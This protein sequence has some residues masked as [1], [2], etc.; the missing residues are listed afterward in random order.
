MY[1]YAKGQ[2]VVVVYVCMC[3]CMCMCVC[4]YVACTAGI[5]LRA[6]VI[7]GLLI[8]LVGKLTLNSNFELFSA[9]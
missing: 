3:M 4:M 7:P 6:G 1:R 8:S 5:C 9:N 2:W